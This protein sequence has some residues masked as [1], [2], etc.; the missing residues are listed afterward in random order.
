MKAH[1]RAK[2]ETEVREAFD[3]RYKKAQA[4]IRIYFK[5]ETDTGR[6]H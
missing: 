4:G 5:E 2:Q 3:K 1:I 6:Y